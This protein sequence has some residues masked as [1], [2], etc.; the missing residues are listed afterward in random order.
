MKITVE[1]E[2]PCDKGKEETCLYEGVKND[3]AGR[4]DLL[5]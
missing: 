1:H 2:I 4:R 5:A 3:D